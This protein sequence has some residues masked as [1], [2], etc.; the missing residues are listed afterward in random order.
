MIVKLLRWGCVG[1]VV[2]SE[3]MSLGSS[4]L[5]QKTSSNQVSSYTGVYTCT[6]GVTCTVDFNTCAR[7]HMYTHTTLR[8]HIHAH[9]TPSHTYQ[10]HNQ[11]W[12][13][14]GYQAMLP[15]HQHWG[16]SELILTLI[17]ASATYQ[18]SFNFTNER[19]HWWGYPGDFSLIVIM[20]NYKQKWDHVICD[21]WAT[22][23]ATLCLELCD[24]GLFLVKER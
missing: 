4:V 18:H 10:W 22:L 14:P 19:W 20:E 15:F 5:F 23:W 2:C 17:M 7:S 16:P 1:V 13:L 3:M 11:T 9:H 24:N 6:H 21:N 8:T 12:A